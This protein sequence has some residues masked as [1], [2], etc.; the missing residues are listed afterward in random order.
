VSD[1]NGDGNLDFVAVTGG[2]GAG[3]QSIQVTSFL[4][5]GN[6][7]FKT[8]PSQMFGNTSEYPVAVYVGDFNQDGNLD[9]LVFLETNGGV[10]QAQVYE[11]FGNGNGS[12]QTAQLL[13]SNFG[14]MT[15]ADVN[16]DG[17]PDIIESAICA[18]HIHNLSWPIRRQFYT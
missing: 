2:M 18:C 6:G 13:F 4:G 9:I 14:P 17:R 3:G 11:L 5:N 12:F 15:V 10:A 7:T 16:N 8:G 1:F